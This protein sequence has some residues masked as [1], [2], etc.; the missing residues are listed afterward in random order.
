MQHNRDLRLAQAYRYIQSGEIQLLSIDI[1]DTLLWRKL[2]LPIDLFLILGRQLKAQGLLVDAV[3]AEGF[4]A[5]RIEAEK[6][7]RQK[8][9]M[10]SQGNISEVLLIDIYEELNGVFPKITLEEMAAGKRGMVH[11]ID[12]DDFI[13]LEV[14]LENQMLELDANVAALIQFAS[15]HNVKVILVSDTYFSLKQIEKFLKTCHVDFSSIRKIYLSCEEG[16][17]KR[18]GLFK[19][20]LEE[21]QMDPKLAL[22]IGDNYL[23]D[24]KP[25]EKEN[26]HTIF[27]Q[28][29]EKEFTQILE[30]EWPNDARQR[31]LSL[32][33][34]LGDFGL[35]AL[36]SRLYY[37]E[38]I[39]KKSENAR[40]LWRYGALVLAPLI[41]GFASWIYQRCQEMK[42]TQVLCLMRE[43]RLYAQVLQ[44]LSFWYPDIPLEAKEFWVSRRFLTQACILYCTKEELLAVL[45]IHPSSPYTLATFC[46]LLGIDM[47]Q[48]K[49][50]KKEAHVELKHL[51]FVDKVIDFIRKNPPLCKEIIQNSAVKRKNF[52]QYLSSFIDLPTCKRIVLVDVGWTGTSQGMLERILHCSGFTISVHGL[53]LGTIEKASYSILQGHMREG[54]LLKLGYPVGARKAISRGIYVLEQTAIALSGT[55]S[56]KE[57]DKEGNPVTAKRPV[58]S[59][60]IKEAQI[61][62][63]GI[64]AYIEE[65]RKHL[66]RGVMCFLNQSE[67]MQNQLRQIML[68]AASL[69][70]LKEAQA[71]SNWAHDHVSGTS[72]AFTLGDD[73]YYKEHIGYIKPSLE[74]DWEMTWPAIYMARY[75]KHLALASHSVTTLQLPLKCFLSHDVFLL[76]AYV[77]TGKGWGKRAWKT[78][79]MRSNANRRFYT[80]FSIL[81]LKKPIEKMQL[82]LHQPSKALIRINSIRLSVKTRKESAFQRFA[83][84]ENGCTEEMDFGTEGVK[85]ISFNTFLCEKGDL[86]LIHSFPKEEG[87]YSLKIHLCC[88]AF[89]LE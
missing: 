8:K 28:K 70:T 20:V 54:F 52:L 40:V 33:D 62:V 86:T 78:M 21:E 81:S 4:A 42:H 26:M 59:R 53:Y 87:I 2:P 57:I 15:K 32:D 29:Y 5:L 22:H 66:G 75:D 63:E 23:S 89:L 80:H 44:Q 16:I 71:F 48:M 9:R 18:T 69:P 56:L 58:S 14:D 55:G 3:F 19:K 1:F 68:R 13:S 74:E 72:K 83:F 65:I 76:K 49:P 34:K 46:E 61:V 60:Q 41:V 50:F 12:V 85:R 67:N 82:Q 47:E 30:A 37:H 6:L 77:D 36:R 24:C 84:F 45:N 27:Y 11:E 17:G 88:E 39:E 73:R 31:S 79:K 43:G 51:A 10:Y 7:A 35:S 38:S 64:E 25:A